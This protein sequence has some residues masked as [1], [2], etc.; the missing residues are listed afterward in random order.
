M[1]LKKNYFLLS[2]Q[3]ARVL[4]SPFD[5]VAPFLDPNIWPHNL[6]F[7]LVRDHLRSR[8]DN[9]RY[10]GEKHWQQRR[11]QQFRNGPGAWRLISLRRGPVRGNTLGHQ[12]YLLCREVLFNLI[13]G[14]Q[15]I[16]FDC[17]GFCFVKVLAFRQRQKLFNS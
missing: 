8:D 15:F 12:R 13:L 17:G 9:L 14:H 16:C 2:Y 5:K 7:Q 10:L 1:P 3:R 4:F 6:R 11:F